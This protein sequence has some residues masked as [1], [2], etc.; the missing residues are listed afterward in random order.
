[1]DDVLQVE[2]GVRFTDDGPVE[3]VWVAI[4]RSVG[5]D[6]FALRCFVADED[7]L[8]Q[9]AAAVARACERLRPAMDAAIAELL[10][11]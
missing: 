6:G 8:T 5:P 9:H 10:P 3:G 1:M 7:D 2:R 4:H 11:R